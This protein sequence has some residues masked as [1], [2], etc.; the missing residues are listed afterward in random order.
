[1]EGHNMDEDIRN[2]NQVAQSLCNSNDSDSVKRGADLL[3]VVAE[4]ENQRVLTSKLAEDLSDFR[5]NKKSKDVKEFIVLLAPVVTTFVLAGTLV[6]QSYQF[7]RTERDKDI[8][9]QRQ[10]ESAA[11]QARR[12]ADDAEDVSW[13]DALKLLTTTDKISPAAA[14][15]KRF[16]NSPRHA[17]DALLTSEQLLLLRSSDSTAFHTLFG[18]VFAP[19]KWD[20]LARVEEIDIQL[21]QKINPLLTKAWDVRSGTLKWERVSKQEKTQYDELNTDLDYISEQLAILLKGKRPAS[22]LLDFHSMAF[23]DTDAQGVDLSGADLTSSNLSN[24]NLTGANLSGIVKFDGVVFFGSAWWDSSAIS[25]ELE[26][27]LEV[28]YPLNP[29]TAYASHRKYPDEVYQAALRRLRKGAGANKSQRT[30][31]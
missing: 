14:L 7:A 8:E 13:G 15:L 17:A 16:A 27:Y 3:K 10:R 5:R 24:L 29:A 30:E 2:V 11:A 6:L 26:A 21:Y 20:N 28:N 31:S 19:V 23:W 25:S 22:Q 4:I 1:M 9:A 18:S 12:Q